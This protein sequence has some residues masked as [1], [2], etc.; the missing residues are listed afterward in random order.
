MLVDFVAGGISSSSFYSDFKAGAA[1]TPL[2][3]LTTSGAVFD[4]V[5]Q[6]NNPE[7]AYVDQDALGYA[8]AVATLTSLTVPFHKVMR[9]NLDGTAPIARL[10][11]RTRI[12]LLVGTRQPLVQDAV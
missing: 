8:T 7:L 6:A 1:G 9:L 3:P 4:A 5:L 2:E 10:A 12:T 11:K